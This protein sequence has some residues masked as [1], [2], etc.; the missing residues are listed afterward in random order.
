MQAVPVTHPG[1]VVA[2]QLD[3]LIDR[4]VPLAAAL[5]DNCWEASQPVEERV[6][7]AWVDQ[8]RRAIASIENATEAHDTTAELV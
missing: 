2:D 8:L 4:L 6:A 3:D 5:N 7:R 1:A